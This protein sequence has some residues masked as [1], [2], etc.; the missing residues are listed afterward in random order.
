MTQVRTIISESLEAK[1][2]ELLPSQN[3]FTE[4]LSA[5]SQIVP[6][7]DLTSAAEGSTTPKFLQTAWD[8]ATGFTQTNNT[9]ND[10]ITTTGFWKV[11]YVY[12]DENVANNAVQ[13]LAR[14]FLDD[15]TS[16]KTIWQM[17]SV[18]TS[19]SN[20]TIAAV[21]DEFYVFVAAGQTLKAFTYAARATLNVS[22]RQVATVTGTLVNPLGFTP[23]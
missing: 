15:G 11:S 2:R 12:R 16:E 1:V 22:Y 19:S 4:E 14:L 13:T 8:F 5:Q 9:T 3:G 10:L 6:I 21:E 7:I 23:Q 17:S 18:N 20:E